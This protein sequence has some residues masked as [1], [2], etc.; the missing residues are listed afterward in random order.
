[1]VPSNL[2]CAFILSPLARPLSFSQVKSWPDPMALM[3]MFKW[4]ENVLAFKNQFQSNDRKTT[5]QSRIIETLEPVCTPVMSVQS[6]HQPH[7][8]ASLNSSTFSPFTWLT[9]SKWSEIA[10]SP[11]NHTAPSYVIWNKPLKPCG[12]MSLPL[13]CWYFIYFTE[14]S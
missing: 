4:Q 14:F 6:S 11:V 12:S 3:I 9:R 7:P 8:F 5:V 2:F 10:N 13:K 1:M